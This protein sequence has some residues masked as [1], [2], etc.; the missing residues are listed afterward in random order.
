MSR[1]LLLS[2]L[3][4]PALLAVCV[5]AQE[6][7]T[8]GLRPP[9]PRERAWMAAHL[10]RSATPAR[11]EL[12]RRRIAAGVG[13]RAPGAL[14][15]SVD[16]SALA[17]FP[18]IRSQGS[19]NSCAQFSAVYYVL[20]H[21]TGLAR[22][23][24]TKSTSDNTNKFSPKFTYNL[25]NGGTNDGSW[26]PFEILARHGC[27]T[28][29]TLPTDADY[30]SWA[31]D[32]ITW[33]EAIGY[34]TDQAGS[35]DQLDTDAGLTQLKEYLNNGYVLCFANYIYSWQFT[36][37]G[38]DPATSADD[39]FVGK[40]V[41]SWTNGYDGPHAMT[42]VGYNDN[43]WT[44][45][46]GNQT[47]DAGEKGALRLAN[48]WG[49]SWRDG[50]YCWV[51]YDALKAT[52]AVSGGPRSSRVPAFT[53]AYWL[54]ARTS[55][56]PHALA[57]VTL[58]HAQRNQISLA[59][60]RSTQ[61][62]TTPTTL[63]EPAALVNQGGAL[64]F[65]GGASA[66]DG[67]FVFDLSDIWIPDASPTRL[68]A[69]ATDAFSGSPLA[70]TSFTVEDLDGPG[71][72]TNA[73]A[74]TAD[75]ST[76]L[77][78]VDYPFGTRRLSFATQPGT[79]AAT[80]PMAPAPC[81]EVLG[82][83]GQRDTTFA[84]TVTVLLAANTTG[85]TLSGTT[86]VAAVAGLATFG[87]LRLG[88]PGSGYR[89]EAVSPGVQEGSSATFTV[90]GGSFA[91]P[92][93]DDFS[94]D[95]GWTPYAVATAWQR[96]S[97]V[98]GAGDPG[99]DHSASS[100]NQLLG[101][102]LGGTYPYY[103]SE[104][105]IDSPPL[106]CRGAAQV[107]L[108]F[109]RWL[110]V[111]SGDGAKIQATNNGTTWTDVWSSSATTIRDAA[112]TLCTYDLTGLAAGRD[113]VRVRFLLGPSD[114][115]MYASDGG[116]NIDDVEVVGSGN[117]HHFELALTSPQWGGTPFVGL[118]T[119]RAC[120]STGAT[121]PTF[122]AATSPVTLSVS[123]T[124]AT[125]VL[126]SG[127][128]VLNQAADFVSGVANLTGRLKLAGPA[129]T[130]TLR[131]TAGAIT[132]TA[133]VTLQVA[134][135]PFSDDF[136][137]DQG[138]TGLLANGWMRGPATAGG[139]DPATDHTATADNFLLGYNIGGIYGAWLSGSNPPAV[140]SPPI[141]CRAYAMVEL[142]FWRWLLVDN[143]DGAGIDVSRDGVTWTSVWSNSLTA[144]RDS[145]WTQVSYDVSAVA[146]GQP[147][148]WIRF[149]MGGS[150]GS[151][152]PTWDGGWS[153]DDL[154]L[155]GAT[156]ALVA[157]PASVTV[158]EGGTQTVQVR[159][160]QRPP[161]NVTVT[162][163]RVAGDS[164]LTVQSGASLTF[165]PANWA[166]SQTVTLAAAEDVDGSWSSA[167]FRASAPGWQAVDIA[168]QEVDND[169]RAVTDVTSLNVP[170]GGTATFQVWL[171]GQPSANKAVTVTRASGDTD[172]SVTGG[173]SLVFTPTNWNVPQTVTLAA[174]HDIDGMWGTAV[175]R[176]SVPGWY[177]VDVTAR[178][179]DDDTRILAD[180]ASLA[181]PEGATAT[182]TVRLAGQP[183][184]N[185]AVSVA[186]VSG[187]TD[188]TVQSG[189][190]LTFTPSNWNVPQTVTLAAAVDGD[191]VNGSALFRASASGWKS[192]DVT[193]T[194]AEGG[195]AL[196]VTA[197][198][199]GQGVVGQLVTITASAVGFTRPQ[200]KVW[201][202]GPH[203]GGAS[204]WLSLGSYS[205]NRVFTW[206][207]NAAGA[208]QLQAWVREY[209]NPAQK[210]L[211]TTLAYPVVAPGAAPSQ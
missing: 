4:M 173:G 86:S 32:A 165:T 199:A 96:G 107:Q 184:S 209:G 198:P 36:T 1:R 166:T 158:P 97:A 69:Q 148:V 159:L 145:G 67:T 45:L 26:F 144:V 110:N 193:A 155:I 185:K 75:A 76:I 39:A 182:F 48:S 64:A 27:P 10:V 174:A 114:G 121:V 197:S 94:T 179:A 133:N 105:T 42:V 128:A 8:T 47:V 52:S 119:I 55:Y 143:N 109:W 196:S 50:G 102:N 91:L 38:N 79:V 194:E 31:R 74:K 30:T 187:D 156:P 100:D 21:M 53:T 162:V 18:P 164:D 95:R 49:T 9:D 12:A 208:Y 127:G 205:E 163:T 34:R 207:P 191:A 29:A 43:V 149:T 125:P 68:Y 78:R 23:W 129:G 92:F 200:Y 44:D 103:M 57:M 136:G 172:I 122:N 137:S 104:T 19:L 123:P 70:L 138:W 177:G 33:R 189:A 13:S 14:P 139:G 35:V 186:R 65:D 11:N 180:P 16:N 93:S 142:R 89:L 85:T 25:V 90:T 195:R 99:T 211:A 115:S 160:D 181:V 188:L 190:S 77:S 54:T 168:A 84:G 146:G 161:A 7:Q 134:A 82:A 28:W 51:A 176:V 170:E 6:P 112:W 169:S 98:S 117:V 22:G 66:V 151:Y 152:Y 171:A 62:E 73:N 46:N 154:Q 201:A 175:I 41:C 131:A 147:N 130:W 116:W 83:G 40:P 56:T 120:D 15:T 118:N 113:N 17:S 72:A 135:M 60:G 5:L 210:E 124:G 204:T 63:F 80:Q 106:D 126:T 192:A 101:Y 141:D 183:S 24:N 2:A 150:N 202:I 20:T 167:T 37:L 153:I 203:N 132:G 58:N 140:V 87:N 59:F 178:E 61:A 206:T 111:H 3:L 108:R 71:N 157:T 81:V 88:A